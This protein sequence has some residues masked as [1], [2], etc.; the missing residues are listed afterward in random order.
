MNPTSRKET[1]PK[2]WRRVRLLLLACVLLVLAAVAV[3][4]TYVRVQSSGRHTCRVDD[5]PQGEIGVVLGCAPTIHGRPNGYFTHRIRAAAQ[6][7]HAGK[8]N[9][10]LVTG[11]NSRKDYNE[12]DAMKCAL[13]AEGVPE[14][15]IT[16]D[17]AGLRTLDS[18]VRAD[19]IF[20][21]GRI[22]V[23]S[24][25]FHNERA[26]AVASHE[27]I[28]AY[29]LDAPDIGRRSHRLRS[30]VRERAARVAM[31]LDLFLL[32]R[33]PRHMGPKETLPDSAVR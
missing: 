24:Q 9:S 28:E 2:K 21:A 12:A 18:I 20:G 11:D 16:C 10:L 1:R 17:Y 7:W 15:R 3:S 25:E 14:Q 4:E 31:M 30:W 13:V 23:V 8:V 19:K 6:L 5:V 22:V 32:D 33:Q 26:L 27:G 29:G